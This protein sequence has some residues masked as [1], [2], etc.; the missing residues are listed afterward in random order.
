VGLALA[1]RA[2]RLVRVGTSLTG[3]GHAL[4][5]GRAPRGLEELG[6]DEVF[7]A[8]WQQRHE[9]EPPEELVRALRELLEEV[10]GGE[11]AGAAR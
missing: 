6:I 4:G 3:T 9:G 1:E 11:A 5:D 7:R 2:V 10:Q 8:R